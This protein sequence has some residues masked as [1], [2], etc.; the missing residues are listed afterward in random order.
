MPTYLKPTIN[1]NCGKDKSFWGGRDV[2]CTPTQPSSPIT[3]STQHGERSINMRSVPFPFAM[4]DWC[5]GDML[6][7]AVCAVNTV[8]FIYLGEREVQYPDAFHSPG[9]VHALYIRTCTH[10]NTI[11]LLYKYTT[12]LRK[13]SLN[14][15]FY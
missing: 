8:P 7:H 14:T 3:R 4:P 6:R 12:I 9:I 15:L 5:T 2:E 10:R 11:S 13:Y 1:G